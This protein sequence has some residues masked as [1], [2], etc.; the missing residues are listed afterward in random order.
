[1]R[2]TNDKRKANFAWVKP[3]HPSS[4]ARILC[5]VAAA[6]RA[7]LELRM[8]QILPNRDNAFVPREKLTDYL[9]SET[10]SV[11]WPKA[12]FF[13]MHGFGDA[14]MAELEAQLIEV[15]RSAPVVEVL[16]NPYGTKYVIDG[17]VLSPSGALL[18][19]RTVWIIEASD[20]RPR[21]VTAFPH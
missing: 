9:L 19:I 11:G 21:F 3:L 16:K 18:S 17:R 7:R 15:A 14:N 4:A 6:I 8:E 20:E 12:V 13:R 10:H 1:M 2:E 5:T